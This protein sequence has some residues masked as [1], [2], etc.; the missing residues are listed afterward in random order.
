LLSTPPAP[1]FLRFLNEID[2]NL[3]AGF[4]VHL[5]TDNYGTHKVAKVRSWLARHPRYQVHFTPTSGSWLNLAERL[6]AEVTERC[7][8]RGSHTAVRV[9]EKAMLDYLNQRNQHPQPFTW[10]ADTVIPSAYMD[11]IFASNPSKRVWCFSIS[12]GSKV[13]LRSRGTSIVISPASPFSVFGLFPF[14]ELPLP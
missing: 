10:T 8:R 13:P 1:E 3:P 7:V 9:L 14:R 4:D 11:R 6:F 2:L 12:C 5:I